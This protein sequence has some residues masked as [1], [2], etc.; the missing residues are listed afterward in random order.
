VQSA[1][2]PSTRPRA[3]ADG[4][5]D[6]FFV[7]THDLGTSGDKACLYRISDR[8][9]LIDS[10]LVEYPLLLTPDGGAEERAED[11]WRAVSESSR[12]LLERTGLDPALVRGL[13]FCSQMQGSVLVDD[14]G[15]ALRNPMIYLDGR[16]QAQL[17]RHLYTGLFRIGK[18]NALKTLRSLVITGGL[19]GTAKDPLWK[20]H[21]VKDNEPEVFARVWKWLDVKDYLTLRSTGRLG[22]TYDSAHLTW[23]FDT[24]PG[25]LGWSRSL[26]RLFDVNPD[27]LPP[28]VRSVDVVGPLLPEAAEAMGLAAGTPVFGGGGDTTLIAVGTGCT[29]VNDIHIYIGTSGWV[30]ATVDRRMVDTTNFVASVLGAIPGRYVYTAEQE[31]AGV[32]LQWV[33]DHLALD[34]IGVY[35]GSRHVASYAFLDEVVARTA[36]GAGGIIFTPWL[37]GNRS[38]REDPLARGMFFNLSLDTGKQ[39]M[40][41]A[42]LEGVAYHVRWMLEAVE[43]RVPRRDTVRLAGGGARSDV[44]CQIIADVTGRRVE[45]VENALDAGTAGAAVVCGVGLG[46]IPSFEAAGALVKVERTYLPRPET[47][48]V[49]ERQFG[50]FRE[51]YGRNRELFRRLNSGPLNSGPLNGGPAAPPAGRSNEPAG[52]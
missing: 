32:C 4:G 13:A 46:L 19:A 36:P 52:R 16:A 29:K 3:A 8:V 49:Y 9:E 34:E 23:V 17:A 45:V 38:P 41:R 31:T 22:M 18:W 39:Q 24:R 5:L 42:V 30:A 11:W 25:R 1:T 2:T 33:R 12:A 14:K 43:R 26:C 27:H 48:E 28:V 47:R 37:H 10:H 7:L 15:N 44:W 6:G 50:V 20:Y 40:I 51:L 35:P 21:W